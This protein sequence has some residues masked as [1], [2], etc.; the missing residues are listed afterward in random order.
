MLIDLSNTY[1]LNKAKTYFNKLIDKGA[2][3]ELKEKKAVRSINQNSY[4]HALFSLFAIEF[5]HN[6]EFVKQA[7]YKLEVNKT[8]FVTSKELDAKVFK[9]VRSTTDLTTEET[10]LCIDRF[11]NYSA[12]H[13]LYLLSSEEYLESKFYIDQEIDRHKEFL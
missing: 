1:Q 12:E 5:G 9:Y 11:R 4:Q 6:L 10:T 2:K 8:T 7:I 3:I 13:G